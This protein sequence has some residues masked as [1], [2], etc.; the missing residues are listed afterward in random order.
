MGEIFKNGL[1]G[2]TVIYKK[3]VELGEFIDTVGLVVDKVIAEAGTSSTTKFLI[4]DNDFNITYVSYN[5]IKKIVISTE[6][7]NIDNE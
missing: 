2:Q 5:K 3:Y 6:F 4:M 7:E 1:V